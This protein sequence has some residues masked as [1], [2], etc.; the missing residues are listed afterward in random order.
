MTI[1]PDADEAGEKY[2]EAIAR[3]LAPIAG[4]MKWLEPPKDA[5]PGWDA[6][7]ALAEGWDQAGAAAFLATA[8]WGDAAEVDIVKATATA[9]ATQVPM[10]RRLSWAAAGPRPTSCSTSLRRSSCGTAPTDKP[11]EYSPLAQRRDV[12]DL[13]R[14]RHQQSRPQHRATRAAALGT[15]RTP[16]RTARTTAGCSRPTAS[17]CN[18]GASDGSIRLQSFGKGILYRG[19]IQP[20]GCLP[21]AYPR[22]AQATRSWRGVSQ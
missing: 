10:A 12:P 3:F 21:L 4:S 9:M 2:A 15:G 22:L 11:V 16:D 19:D 18:H 17:S 5:K 1:W 20:S 13:D 7:D 8:G 6:A 14:R